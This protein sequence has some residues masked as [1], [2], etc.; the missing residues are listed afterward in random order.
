M[1]KHR[2]RRSGRSAAIV[3]TFLCLATI[4]LLVGF[5]GS[6]ILLAKIE[7][8]YLS[9]QLE[10][11]QKEA[12]RVAS[13]LERQISSGQS[14][15]EVKHR[16]QESLQNAPHDSAGFLCLVNETG[17]V[18]CHPNPDYVGKYADFSTWVDL[19]KA[20]NLSFI[21]RLT[22]LIRGPNPHDPSSTSELVSQ[23]AVADT[24][25]LVSVHVNLELL[26]QH[27]RRLWLVILGLAI[28]AAIIITSVGTVAVRL[29][30]R[31]Y[32]REIEKVNQGLEEEVSQ[33]TAALQKTNRDLEAIIDASPIP[34]I[35][36]NLAGHVHLWNP[37]AE[38]VFGW[39]QEEVLGLPNPIIPEERQVEFRGL[40]KRLRQ[41]HV[42][43]GLE[44]VRR[45]KD[46]TLLDVSL[47]T[48]ILKD[49]QDRVIGNISILE[50]ISDRKRQEAVIYHLAMHDPLTDLAN[51]RLLEQ[52]MKRAL[53]RSRRGMDSVLLFLDLDNFKLVN[54]TLGHPA[55]D[56]LLIQLVETLKSAIRSEDL[57]ARFGG[58][59]FA[60]LMEDTSLDAGRSVAQKVLNTVD[61]FR[62]QIYDHTFALSASIG[63]VPLDGNL[64]VHETLAL[65]DSALQSAKE[66]GKN[67]LVA[68]RYEKDRHRRLSEVAQW[69]ARIK[70][71]FQQ[72]RFSIHYQPVVGLQDGKIHHFEA[73][74]RMRSEKGDLVPP[75]RF[76]PPA[77]QFNVMPR[78]D[79]W[80]LKRVIQALRQHPEFC[81]FVNLSGLTLGDESLLDFIE[82][83]LGEDSAL[84]GRLGFEITETVAIKD[85][86]R[87]QYWMHRLRDQGC[88]FA[89]DDFGI[90]FSSFLYLRYL[91]FDFIKIDGSF[92]DK[93]NQDEVSYAIVSALSGVVHAMGKQVIAEKVESRNVVATLVK[94]GI[95]F[96][97]GNF[98]GPPSSDLVTVSALSLT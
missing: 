3:W 34:I 32:E 50:D 5:V 44:T 81:I 1:S 73:L 72:K 84:A 95:S 60:V 13:I 41:G 62:F 38:K 65:A 69:P 83:Q 37:A 90:G 24:P 4:S 30:E 79:R 52:E 6:V 64:T 29:V 75:R 78:L 82:D 71:A 36:L 43:I 47:S 98:C 74:I 21:E 49:Y 39:S 2:K 48:A 92:I 77:E 70:D 27:S 94:M 55:G 54:D 53:N 67:Q 12:F 68:F 87:C 22:E 96:G 46:G 28:P 63:L 57:L 18:L 80:V 97:Q 89:L 56:Q 9:I 33:R 25:W 58:D 16:F 59:E 14:M 20:V 10:A 85:L 17:Q 15:E 23:E 11:N 31:R 35:S 45:R 7:E 93:I 61:K 8:T 51:R 40:L 42:F 66:K 76:V 86:E 91:P 26:K 19:H 88:R